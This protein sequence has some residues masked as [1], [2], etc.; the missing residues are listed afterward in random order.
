MFP[1]I[2]IPYSVGSSEEKDTAWVTVINEDEDI[3]MVVQYLPASN[4][5]LVITKTP[6]TVPTQTQGPKEA[7]IER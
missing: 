2:A 5:I 6:K 3:N 1:L 7:G 4:T